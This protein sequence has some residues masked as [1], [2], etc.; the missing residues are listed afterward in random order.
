MK[1]VKILW[2]GQQIAERAALELLDIVAE[3]NG[4]ERENW[5]NA[6]L[7]KHSNAANRHFLAEIS[8]GQLEVQVIQ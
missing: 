2:N 6:W 8:S 4:Y 3:S 1:H 7:G 5:I